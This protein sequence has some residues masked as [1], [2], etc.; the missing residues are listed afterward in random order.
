M[1]AKLVVGQIAGVFL[2]FALALFL[3]AG[4]IAWPA[5][6]LFLALFVGFFASVTLWLFT[7]NPGLLRERMRM[8]SPNQKRWDKALF[9]LQ[10]VL[11]LAWLVLMSLDAGRF[12]WSSV[13]VWLQSFGAIVLVGSFYL[14]FLTFRENPYLS[15]VV[16]V[17]K[18]R[19]Q[20]V[21]STGPYRYVRHP[22]YSA[23]L[24]LVVGTALLLGSWYGVL[25]GLILMI[26][27]ARRAELEERALRKELPGYAAYMARVKYRLIPHVW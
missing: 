25:F 20:R 23:I 27:I 8:S 11:F 21:V 19:G 6:W 24:V 1:H 10:N 3:P 16:R 17:Q 14:L 5:G 18:E 22:M 2:V 4:T 13:P 15:T 26:T 9:P 12:H 7:H